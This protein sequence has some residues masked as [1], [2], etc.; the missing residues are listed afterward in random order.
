M[1]S[2]VRRYTLAYERGKFP[3]LLD[4]PSRQIPISPSDKLDTRITAD[5]RDQNGERQ[6]YVTGEIKQTNR[7]F[8]GFRTLNKG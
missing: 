8:Q 6:N 3:I 7:Y 4:T 1:V 2:S 5:E